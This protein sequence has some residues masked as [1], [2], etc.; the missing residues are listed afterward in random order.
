MTMVPGS[1]GGGLETARVSSGWGMSGSFW[2]VDCDDQTDGLHV[3]AAGLGRTRAGPMRS[4][5]LD[6]VEVAVAAHD[7]AG[8]AV[9]DVGDDD[10]AIDEIP[11]SLRCSR[12]T[13]HPAPRRGLSGRRS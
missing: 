12:L 2:D 7:G 8:G 5:D 1:S 13:R 4:L 6:S 3:A 11:A 9:A 10:S